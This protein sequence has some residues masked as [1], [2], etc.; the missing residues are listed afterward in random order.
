MSGFVRLLVGIL[1]CMFVFQGASAMTKADKTKD[2]FVF[3]KHLNSVDWLKELPRGML[4]EKVDLKYSSVM[5]EKT[6]KGHTIYVGPIDPY[7]GGDGITVW[8]DKNLKLI[9]YEVERLEPAP[10]AE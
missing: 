9:N 8:L 7:K 2:E 6:D 3:A 5:L 4:S 10:F 1:S